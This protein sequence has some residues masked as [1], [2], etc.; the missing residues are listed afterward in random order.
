MKPTAE[1]GLID[2]FIDMM[3]AE[4]GAAKNTLDAYRRDCED[5]ADFLTAA[6]STLRKADTEIPLQFENFRD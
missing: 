5:L 4:R 3:A 1:T 6:G 2:A